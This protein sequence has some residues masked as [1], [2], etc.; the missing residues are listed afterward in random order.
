MLDYRSSRSVII[1]SSNEESVDAEEQ[2][3]RFR[4]PSF[5]RAL[6]EARLHNLR[7]ILTN[8]TRVVKH[9]FE[10]L[11]VIRFRHSVTVLP[12]SIAFIKVNKV[13]SVVPHFRS[14]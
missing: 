11:S 6:L 10:S 4:V 8:I 7:N 13:A 5:P 9:T 2:E 14:F 1:A 3:R 12:L